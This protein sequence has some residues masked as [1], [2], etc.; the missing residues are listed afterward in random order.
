MRFR[1]R[2]ARHAK[3]I[4]DYSTQ[5]NDVYNDGATIT[6]CGK[7]EN[8]QPREFIVSVWRGVEGATINMTNRE[9]PTTL[10]A[11]K[12]LAEKFIKTLYKLEA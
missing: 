5:D 8:G 10:D 12:E 11:A 3:R 9:Y 6:A 2:W 1:D 4:Y 7:L